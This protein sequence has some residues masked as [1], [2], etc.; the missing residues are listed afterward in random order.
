MKDYLT[1]VEIRD[2]VWLKRNDL[3]LIHGCNG[4][5]ALG[6]NNLIQ[7]G[8]SLGYNSFVTVGSRFSPQCD[9]VSAICEY[10]KVSAHLFM[11]RGAETSVI[12]N[13]KNRVKSELHRDSK[14]GYTNV[15][16]SYAKKFSELNNCYYIP[17]GMKCVENIKCVANQ[18]K[19]IPDSIKRIVVPVGSG[20]TFCGILHGLVKYHRTD[21]KVLGVIT[22]ANPEKT[23]RAFSPICNPI[24][25]S[26]VKYQENLIPSKLY[27]LKVDASIG[28]IKLDPIYEAKCAKFLHN[29]D[30][31]WIVGYHD[32]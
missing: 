1:P 20:V 8:L 14:V 2:G 19:N 21:V 31:F 4:G 27:S 18:V 10:Y 11:P 29:G 30:L 12:K 5:K 25:Y 7:K 16:I 15:L 3:Y 6:A 17:F 24:K 13:I 32:I 26:L 9:I 28:G 23:I 22:G